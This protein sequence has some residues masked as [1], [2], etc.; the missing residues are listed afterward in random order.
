MQLYR[1]LV[2]GIDLL[3]QSGRTAKRVIWFRKLHVAIEAKII[4]PKFHFGRQLSSLVAVSEAAI[5]ECKG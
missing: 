1:N 5:P 2:G 4:T 3:H